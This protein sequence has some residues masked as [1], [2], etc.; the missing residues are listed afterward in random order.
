MKKSF[1]L[2]VVL[3]A[4]NSLFAN[5]VDANFAKELG[6]KFVSANF[7]QKSNVLELVYTETSESGEPCF[8]I[9]NVSNNGFIIVSA[10]DA[11]RPILGYSENGAFDANNI[12][13]GVGFMMEIYKLGL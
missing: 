8:Y 11:T 12:V 13:P 10:D 7:V 9:F 3:L 4:F 2:A 6:Q 5:P 1:L